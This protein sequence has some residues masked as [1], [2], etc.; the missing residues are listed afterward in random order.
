MRG[1]HGLEPM[2]STLDLAVDFRFVTQV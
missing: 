1:N 2:R